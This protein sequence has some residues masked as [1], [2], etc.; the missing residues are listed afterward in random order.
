MKN[1]YSQWTWIQYD[2]GNGSSF[3]AKNVFIMFAYKWHSHFSK[4]E[5]FQLALKTQRK[6]KKK[7]REKQR[8]K[9]Y[10]PFLSN[11]HCGKK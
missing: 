3:D 2:D 9:N 4:A 10:K 7:K 1:Q 5:M 8:N 11:K 6:W